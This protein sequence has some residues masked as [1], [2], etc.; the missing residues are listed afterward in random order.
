MDWPHVV[1]IP[2]GSIY[3]S[4]LS[5]TF[6]NCLTDDEVDM[7]WPHVG[8]VNRSK[9]LTDDEVDIDWLH[10]VVVPGTRM[11]V[12]EIQISRV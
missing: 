9:C 5:K 7:D 8:R 3:D 10:V 2:K 4:E 6:K 12:R 1:V 11:A